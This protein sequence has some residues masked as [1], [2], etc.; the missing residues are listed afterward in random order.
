MVTFVH[1]QYGYPFLRVSVR[2]VKYVPLLVD[3][4]FVSKTSRCVQEKILSLHGE[5]YVFIVN[6][7]LVSGWCERLRNRNHVDVSNRL[8]HRVGARPIPLQE[9]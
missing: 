8:N 6:G 2:Q 4:T 7:L 9:L 5:D 3:V 1:G